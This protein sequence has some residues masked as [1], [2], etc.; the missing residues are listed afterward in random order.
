MYV[1]CIDLVMCVYKI[2]IGQGNLDRLPYFSC[3]ERSNA[4]VLSG[5][6]DMTNASKFYV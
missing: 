6:V 1:V 3:S 2:C 4:T 5:G